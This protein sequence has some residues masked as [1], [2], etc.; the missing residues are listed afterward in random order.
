LELIRAVAPEQDCVIADIGGGASLLVDRLLDQGYHE[1]VV[2]D[3][4]DAALD[5]ARG[6]LGKRCTDVIW[7]PADARHLRL[8]KQVD[9]WHDRAVFHFLTDPA[10]REAYLDTVKAALKVGGHIVMA[11]FGPDGP[12]RCSGLAVE[13]YDCARLSEFFGAEF[14]PVRCFQRQHLTPAGA[15][16][17]FTY[18][19]F[20]RLGSQSLERGAQ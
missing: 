7:L 6:R 2:V 14:E 11:T 10:D 16:Q 5:Q 9:V 20:R 12:E 3:I 19:V 8:P 13:R 15:A 4:S 18:A 1:P 17:E